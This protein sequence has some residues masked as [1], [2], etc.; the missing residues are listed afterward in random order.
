MKT[1]QKTQLVEQKSK[2]KRASG[3]EKMTNHHKNARISRAQKAQDEWE[4]TL[5]KL[6]LN[7]DSNVINY[8]DEKNI[9]RAEN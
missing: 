1:S 8:G 5:T 7:I 3:K 9:S 4:K 6:E 2:R